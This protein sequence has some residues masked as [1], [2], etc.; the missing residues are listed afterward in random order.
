MLQ[1]DFAPRSIRCALPAERLSMNSISKTSRNLNIDLMRVIAMIFVIAIHINSKP[2]AENPWFTSAFMA[3]LY[4]CNGW[5]YFL[6][7]I[8]V[9][10]VISAAIAYLLNL[11]LIH[12]LQRVIKR[13][14]LSK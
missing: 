13:F 11:L 4:F 9:T 5:F 3:M 14:W 8:L 10:L 7:T 1:A 2:A 12:P 6:E